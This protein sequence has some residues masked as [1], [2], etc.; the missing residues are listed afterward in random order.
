MVDGM[1]LVEIAVVLQ[2][3]WLTGVPCGSSWDRRQGVVLQTRR[4]RSCGQGGRCRS[5]FLS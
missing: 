3:L 5:Q 1:H 4:R 2:A